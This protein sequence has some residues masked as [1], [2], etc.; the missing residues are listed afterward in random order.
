MMH[1]NYITYDVR[2]NTDIINIGSYPDIMVKSPETESDAQPYWYACTIGVFHAL[3]S[4][5]HT[6]VWEKSLHQMDFLWV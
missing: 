3:V 6:G 1:I 5:L 4:L 2:H